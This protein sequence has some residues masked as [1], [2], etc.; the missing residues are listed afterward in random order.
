MSFVERLSNGEDIDVRLDASWG[1][2]TEFGEPVMLDVTVS[3]KNGDRGYRLSMCAGLVIKQCSKLG[4]KSVNTGGQ[5]LDNAVE[6]LAECGLRCATMEDMVP[7]WREWHLNDMHSGTE[8]QD[9]CLDEYRKAN[10]G[11]RYDYDEACNILKR[12][13]MYEDKNYLVDGKP[14]RYGTGHLFREIPQDVLEELCSLLDKGLKIEE[15]VKNV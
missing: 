1:P 2:D 6:Y 4:L 9:A 11:W 14:Y 12:H 10:P 7:I 15:S 5:C 13:D 3:L 8:A